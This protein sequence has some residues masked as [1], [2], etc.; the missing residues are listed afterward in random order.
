MQRQTVL[1][2]LTVTFSALLLSGC[3]LFQQEYQY[4]G[5]LID[6]PLPVPNFELTT[7]DNQPFQL[8]DAG[9]NFVLVYFGYTFCPDVCPLTL[10]DIKKALNN[11]EQRNKVTVL[12]ISVDPERDTPDIVSEYAATF[13]PTFIGL[14]SDDYANIQKVMTPFGAYAEK[15]TVNESAAGYLV[16]HTARLYLVTPDHGLK[17]TYPFG[18]SAENLRDDLEHL[19][20]SQS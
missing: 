11:L 16:N 19:L 14:S 12:F 9:N 6:P 15:E 7:A 8:T 18:F 2:F 17:L 20:T 3:N 5:T 4:K 1:F 13:D 10:A